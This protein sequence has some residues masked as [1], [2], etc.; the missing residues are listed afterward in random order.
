VLRMAMTL[1]LDDDEAELLKTMAEQ[2]GVSQ[3]EIARRAIL[4]RAARTSLHG[5]VQ[6]SGKRAVTRYAELLERL[7]Q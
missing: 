1:R 2:E 4:E 6:E 5:A 7:A 3:H